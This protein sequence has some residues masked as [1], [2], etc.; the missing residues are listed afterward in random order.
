MKVITDLGM[1]EMQLY[2]LPNKMTAVCEITFPNG[3]KVTGLAPVPSKEGLSHSY[4]HAKDKALETVKYIQGYVEAEGKFNELL[5]HQRRSTVAV[6]HTTLRILL[7]R[8][9]Q[10]RRRGNH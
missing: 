3:Y 6:V 1:A 8:L 5:S 9:H 2:Q 10:V 7:R 4:K